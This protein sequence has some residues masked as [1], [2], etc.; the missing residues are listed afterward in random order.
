MTA[1]RPARRRTA[2]SLAFAAVAAL[3]AVA[4]VDAGLTDNPK[5]DGLA[6]LPPMG[7]NTWN[8]YECDIHESKIRE[9]ADLMVS[10]GL[11]AAGYQ[12]LVIDDCW[13]ISRDPDTDRIVEDPALFPSGMK[14][15]ADYVRSKGLKFGIYS[16][17]GRQTCMKRPG[18]LYYEDID[19]RT[20]DSWGV[21][22][23]KYDTCNLGGAKYPD[24]YIRMWNALKNK[25]NTQRDIIY[26]I[27]A[28]WG[29]D[30]PW[31]DAD[32]F[33]HMWRTTP[34]II[35]VF[36]GR[37]AGSRRSVI[38]IL[39]EQAELTQ[40]SGPGGWNDPDMLEIGNGM[41]SNQEEAHFL[42]WAALKAPL[43]IGTHL[44]NLSSQA[45]ALL[46][47]RDVLAVNQDPLGA[48]ARRVQ[49]DGD[50]DVWAGP[51]ADGSVV[52]VMLNRGKRPLNVR[53]DFASVSELSATADSEFAIRDVFKKTDLPVAKGFYT[54]NLQGEYAQMIRIRKP[55]AATATNSP[56]TASP[57]ARP[58]SAGRSW[59][60]PLLGLAA[61]AVSAL[62]AL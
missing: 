10:R 31:L 13:A 6:L 11:L 8:A 39:D 2:A 19:V 20:Y 22:F 61:A 12:Y 26:S 62:A 60:A 27:N 7:Y 34:D 47:D 16:N 15:T 50:A 24:R 5:N 53:L 29:R 51:M 41:S 54:V 48:S 1:A 45:I 3:G 44:A 32:N 36:N 33:C 42:L 28:R 52:A 17:A 23:L 30:Q 43:M 25:T 40:Y 58:S 37:T 49:R 59:A 57:T 56:N 38:A 18:S 9:T 35:E 14:A 46:T 55:G 4:A 21:D